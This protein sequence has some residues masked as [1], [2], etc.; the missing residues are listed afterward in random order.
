MNSFYDFG[1]PAGPGEVVWYPNKENSMTTIREFYS[2]KPLLLKNGES[3]TFQQIL[4]KDNSWWDECHDFIQWI[5]PTKTPSNYCP[6]APLL[7]PEDAEWLKNNHSIMIQAAMDR[8]TAFLDTQ[9]MKVLNHNHLRITRMIEMHKL[10]YGE[11]FPVIT[12]TTLCVCYLPYK[13]GIDV[14]HMERFASF[15][16][17]TFNY[18][19]NA[20]DAH[21]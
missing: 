20:L 6:T 15:N 12:F 9:N 16:W 13:V 8:F 10:V 19:K 17:D 14:M 1:G 7:T 2:G 21:F 5:F 3:L 11:E 4:F 18:W